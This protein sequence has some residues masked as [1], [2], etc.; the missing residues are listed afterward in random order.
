M[1][2]PPTTKQLQKIPRLYSTQKTP[3]EDKKV[4]MKF[5][6]GE[7]KWYAIEYDGKDTFF[8]YVTSPIEPKGTLGYFS[9]KELKNARAGM[10]RVDRDLH[11]VSP[12][13]PKNLM[14]ILR[15]DRII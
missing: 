10:I 1:W 13:K 5:F 12:Y 11:Q 14:T 9:L 3:K 7:W 6:I 2:N 8:G 4:Y 15:E